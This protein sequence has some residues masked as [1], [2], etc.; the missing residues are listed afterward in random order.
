MKYKKM[1]RPA[2]TVLILSVLIFGIYLDTIIALI[3]ATCVA[4]GFEMYW[5]K[6]EAQ[7]LSYQK[8]QLTKLDV[9]DLSHTSF[10]QVCS[11]S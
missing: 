5:S 2:S 3:G 9:H 1:R 8:T 11:L 6:K 4:K 7:Y 10:E